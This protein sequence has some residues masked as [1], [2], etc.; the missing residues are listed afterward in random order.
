M[1][2]P[3][4]TSAT[5]WVPCVLLLGL[6][7][8]ICYGFGPTFSFDIH[9][10]FSHPVKG[11]LGVDDLPVKGSVDYYV[12]M[13]HRDRLIRARHLAAIDGQSSPL[14]FANGNDT[15]L[16]SSLGFLHYANVS[17]GTPSMSFLVALDTGSD[18]FWLPCDCKKDS[19]IDGLKSSSSGKEIKLNIYSPNTSS[20]SKKVS[21]DSTFC[22]QRPCSSANSNCAY[23][24]A[25]LS[26]NTSSMGVLVEDVLHLVTDDDQPKVVNA[27][28]TFGCGQIQTGTFLS[29]AAPNGLFGLGMEDISVPSV[30]ARNGLASNSFSMCF[31]ADGIGKINFG[32]NGSSE[33]RETPF[34][35]MQSHPTYNISITRITVG[36]SASELEFSAIFDSGTSFTLLSDPAYAFISESFNSQVQEKR[37]SPDSEIPFEYC[38]ELS[39][40]QN[41]YT[42]PDMNLTMKGGD[43]YFLNDPT[44]VVQTPNGG[45]LYCLALLKSENINIIGQNFM[46]G[47]HLVFDREKMVLGW[48]DSNC[49][50][51]ENSNILPTTP[52]HSPAVSPALA[53]NPETKQSSGNTSPIPVA[54][55]S[56]KWK[57]FTCTLTIL[58]VSYLAIV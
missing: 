10:R 56:S 44:A 46:V 18:L 25:Y 16:I 29:G 12:S 50:N 52:S 51:D 4:F 5:L 53:V 1:A 21:C 40:N 48:K 20:T 19:C 23:E 35:V 49:Y 27:Q 17:V 45:Y 54:N 39:A 33:Q 41:N 43:Q 57:S 28:I 31:G 34:H 47:Y 32:N 11:F 7:S 22:Q 15:V 38:Y 37:H 30:L 3:P 6:S 58:L 2:W 14:T 24:V 42:I 9:H 55:H 36:T 13:A 26:S 8:R